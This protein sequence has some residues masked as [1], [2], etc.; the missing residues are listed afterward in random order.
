LR[1]LCISAGKGKLISQEFPGC[2][3][4]V[5]LREREP[6]LIQELGRAAGENHPE[7]SGHGDEM[8]T[9]ETAENEQSPVFLL[10]HD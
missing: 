3:A 6:Y 1:D 7:D 9:N 8:E 5:Q 10:G 2:F 4:G